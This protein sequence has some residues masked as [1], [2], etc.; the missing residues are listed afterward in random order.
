MAMDPAVRGTGGGHPA[1]DALHERMRELL[2]MTGMSAGRFAARYGYER[3]TVTQY[4]G[5]EQLCGWDFMKLLMT[6]AEQGRAARGGPAGPNPALTADYRRETFERF[7]AVLVMNGNSDPMDGNPDL[8]TILDLTGKVEAVTA[9]L[10]PAYYEIAGL[11]AENARLRREGRAPSDQAEHDLRT[12]RL[13][14]DQ[15]RA[16]RDLLRAQAA[17]AEAQLP[18]G[19]RF[20]RD[21]GTPAPD[22][23][24]QP[25]WWQ[26]H[27]STVPG[28]APAPPRPGRP[29]GAWLVAGALAVLLAGTGSWI[30]A[31]TLTGRSAAASPPNGTPPTGTPTTGTPATGPTQTGAPATTASG[32]AGGFTV[33]YSGTSIT[34]PPDTTISQ[35]G[36]S[37]L[38]FDQPRGFVD[39]LDAGLDETADLRSIQACSDEGQG[40][41]MNTD[42]QWG[43]APAQQP[44]PA[45]CLQDAQ[46]NALP[47][48]IKAADFSV[49]SAYCMLTDVGNLAWFQ[50]TAANPDQGGYTVVATL[51]SQN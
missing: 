34:M 26:E 18:P 3:S 9:Q 42:R 17:A 46:A 44:T 37:Y 31:T 1:W 2:E 28:V 51:W 6:G 21:P 22:R 25:S 14:A 8:P 40:P 36:L 32:A 47:A 27:A 24:P 48:Q 13:E 15:L 16:A 38:D 7:R 10:S 12:R 29:R 41:T 50:V 5:S 35:C 49:G 30:A 11:E 33:K 23:E 19:Q 39:D 20:L 43:T 45:Q 4:F